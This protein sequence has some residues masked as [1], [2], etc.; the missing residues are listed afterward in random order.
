VRFNP[1]PGWPPAPEGWRP[2]PGWQPDKSWPPAPPGWRL[3]I[4]DPPPS[5]PP[6]N[7]QPVLPTPRKPSVIGRAILRNTIFA[8]VACALG[9]AGFQDAINIKHTFADLVLAVLVAFIF[10]WC[11]RIP[12]SLL[13]LY[14]TR[15]HSRRW[16]FW[17]HALA[18]VTTI[19]AIAGNEQRPGKSPMFRHVVS[20]Q[21]ATVGLLYYLILGLAF[22]CV[23][24]IAVIVI[25]LTGRTRKGNAS[26]P[27]SAGQFQ[28]GDKRN[29]LPR[30]LGP[31]KAPSKDA[32]VLAISI[33]TAIASL[34][35]GLDVRDI[36]RT[37]VA[38][39]VGAMGLYALYKLPNARKGP[40]DRDSRQQRT[41]GRHSKNPSDEPAPNPDPRS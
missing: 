26:H 14:I 25:D 38:L 37:I 21:A 10:F 16:I 27:A 36:G 6:P 1:P 23:A 18:V 24:A 15:K 22:L 32:T 9:P 40:T 17:P 41:T 8:L 13:E 12:A 28:S 11:L 7:Q 31:Y 20:I 33:V 30:M 19:V 2:L 35:Q 4:E 3:W 5:G 39:A 29:H 34:V